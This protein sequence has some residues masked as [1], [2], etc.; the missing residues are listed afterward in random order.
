MRGGNEMRVFNEE[1]VCEGAKIDL[2]DWVI[3]TKDEMRVS[4]FY[5]VSKFEKIS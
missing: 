5:A 4:C 3:V 2:A 1:V